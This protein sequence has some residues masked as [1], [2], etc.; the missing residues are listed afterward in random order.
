MPAVPEFILR[1]LYVKGSLQSEEDGFSF[2]LLNTFAPATFIDFAVEVD[3]KL[4]AGEHIL[5]RAEGGSERL[6]SEIT[7][8]A[9]FPFSVGVEYTLIVHSAPFPQQKITLH[10]DT[11]EAGLVSFTLPLKKMKK[12]KHG[13][14][15][16]RWLWAIKRLLPAKSLPANISID[17]ES[18]LG[19]ISPHV[20][21]HFVE[22]L[23][24]CV[25]GGIWT[26]DGSHMRDD[27]VS[28]IRKLQPPNIRY[29]GG[30]F[31][32]GYHWEDGIGPGEKRPKRYD[33]AWNTWESN[34]VGTDEFMML[35]TEVGAEPFLVINDATGT[36]E[37]AARWVA[38]CNEPQNTA[39]GKR[40]AKNGHP[41]PYHVHL[42]G[43]GNEVWGQWQ[44]GHTDAANYA[45]RLREF[46]TAMRA[47]DPAI[48]IIAVGEGI[49][50]D[51]LED[52][53][54]LWNETVLQE[55]G[56][57]I[58]EISFHLYQPERDGWR[59]SYDLDVLHHTIC[60]APL[61]V[62]RIIARMADQIRTIKPLRDIGIAFDEWNLWLPPPQTAKSMHEVVYTMRDALYTA[63][64]LNVFHRHPKMLRIA[65]LAQLV[66]VLPAIVTDDNQAYATSI[67]Y[68]FYM[69]RAMQPISLSPEV[70]VPDYDS[71]Q[72]GN[73]PGMKSVP[74]LDVTAT[75]DELGERLTVG[76]VNRHLTRAIHTQISMKHFGAF[77]RIR[78]WQLHADP[79]ANNTFEK[80]QR[81]AAREVTPPSVDGDGF[82]YTFPAASVTV[83]ALM[84]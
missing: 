77:S 15:S 28:L 38:Y 52:P 75:R 39:Q 9:A 37:E 79:L 44:I 59:E 72:L 48:H 73:I 33:Q 29:P 41:L 47:V 35:C 82:S 31:A 55:T 76:V 78:A 12:T 4:I 68:P 26:G 18:I 65:N 81:V 40:R 60:A 13:A 80:P 2:R 34:Q 22:H 21:G 42:W 3:S 23:E 70:E 67:Y 69:Y 57:L 25:Y 5:L 50:S 46:A 14:V 17:A 63:G 74:Y 62:E 10:V 19:E 6:A 36:P 61:D 7:P 1:K 43:I 58:D 66:N 8:E 45:K 16:N 64:M 49:L 24:R 51:D 83:I 56:D 53:G 27:T 30:N 54:R 71:E 20:Y 11:V 32:S 84:N